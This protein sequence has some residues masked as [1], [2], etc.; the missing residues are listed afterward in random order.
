MQ[1]ARRRRRRRLG[2]AATRSLPPRRP[3]GRLHREDGHLNAGMPRRE[4]PRPDS[5]D[6]G[7]GASEQRPSSLLA[8]EE[9][10]H[11]SGRMDGQENGGNGCGDSGM[12]SA[13]MPWAAASEFGGIGM[14]ARLRK[15][16]WDDG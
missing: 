3:S 7:G 6:G 13:Y 10:T 4:R 2:T 14:A 1:W 12:H 16:A 11:A 9:P 5:R 15:L 8:L